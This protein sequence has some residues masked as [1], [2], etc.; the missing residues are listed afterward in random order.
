MARL[1]QGRIINI[2]SSLVFKGRSLSAAYI[3]SKGAV[4]AL[5]RALARELG[6]SGITVNAV[7][8]GLTRTEAMMAQAG[9]DDRER[10]VV[11]GRSIRR[12]QYPIDLAGAVVF[13]ASPASAFVTG[14]TLVVDGGEVMH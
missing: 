2:A 6:P 9:F 1:R 7:A 13:L 4:I 8:P 11:A 3:A 14:Q 12:A 10:A 5:T